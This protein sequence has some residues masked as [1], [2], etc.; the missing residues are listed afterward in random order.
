MFIQPNMAITLVW[1]W[2][3]VLSA[4]LGIVAR[5]NLM[6]FWPL[7]AL[8][9]LLLVPAFVFSFRYQKRAT[10]RGFKDIDRTIQAMRIWSYIG[11]ALAVGCLCYL[12]F[13]FQLAA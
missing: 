7:T 3:F 11:L 9:L 8:R 5:T 10:A 4:G 12:F 13:A 6:L 2:Q 1:G